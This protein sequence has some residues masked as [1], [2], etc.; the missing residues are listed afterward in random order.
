MLHRVCDR[1]LGLD[2]IMNRNLNHSTY[3]T[4]VFPNHPCENVGREKGPTKEP[5]TKITQRAGTA[6]F[7]C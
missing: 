3:S 5:F 6:A 1:L 4:H 2:G 7:T